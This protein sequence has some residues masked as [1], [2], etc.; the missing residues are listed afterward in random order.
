MALHPGGLLVHAAVVVVV[1]TR[2]RKVRV[3]SGA[4]DGGRACLDACVVVLG[5]FSGGAARHHPG[6]APLVTLD[7]PA[8]E[9]VQRYC[10]G[11]YILVYLPNGEKQF[12]FCQEAFFC[13]CFVMFFSH[14]CFCDSNPK[15]NEIPQLNAN[16]EIRKGPVCC[17]WNLHHMVA[18]TYPFKLRKQMERKKKKFCSICLKITQ[19]R[20]CRPTHLV[21][22]ELYLW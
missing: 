11:Q 15:Q 20:L 13:F 21:L 7:E 18:P 22:S 14:F 10:I 8:Q 17:S 2:V 16:Q 12:N 1:V 3:G 6:F 5:P 19:Q 4:G 9:M